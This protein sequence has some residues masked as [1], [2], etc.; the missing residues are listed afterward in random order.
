MNVTP[1]K[2]SRVQAVV[3]PCPSTKYNKA[4]CIYMYIYT[5]VAS[6]TAYYL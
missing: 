5:G 6:I 4:M 2:L 1:H 3:S